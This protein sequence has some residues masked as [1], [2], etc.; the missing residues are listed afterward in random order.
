MCDFSNKMQDVSKLKTFDEL[1]EEQEQFMKNEKYDEYK[2]EI[3]GAF[4][5]PDKLFIGQRIDIHPVDDAF[6][7]VSI[8]ELV[9][10]YRKDDTI[11]EK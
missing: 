5:I 1:L 7:G 4:A 11:F 8:K 3:Y 2:K 9:K 6:N 10:Q